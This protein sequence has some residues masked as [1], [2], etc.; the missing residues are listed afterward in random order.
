MIQQA[1]IRRYEV[2]PTANGRFMCRAIPTI[3][4]HFQIPVT[5]YR[6]ME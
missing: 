4:R 1:G 5:R 3:F 2:V 6:V